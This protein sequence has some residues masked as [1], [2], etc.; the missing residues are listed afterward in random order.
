MQH[1]EDSFLQSGIIDQDDFLDFTQSSGDM[2][3]YP[4]TTPTTVPA[5]LG[6]KSFWEHDSSMADISMD[7]MAD[8]SSF[9][10]PSQQVSSMEDWSRNHQISQDSSSKGP[11]MQRALQPARRH[12]PLMAKPPASSMEQSISNTAFDFNMSSIPLDPFARYVSSGVVDP[13]LIFSFSEVAPQLQSNQ[14]SG[15]ATQRSVSMVGR[16]TGEPYGHQERGSL[17]NKQELRR[18]RSVKENVPQMS[19]DRARFGSPVD[20]NRPGSRRSVSDARP[21]RRETANDSQP[22]PNFAG[23]GVYSSG[24]QPTTKQASRINLTSIPEAA[25][26]NPRTSVTFSIDENGRARTETTVIMDGSRSPRRARSSASSNDRESPQSGS[27]TDEDP[28]TIP[29]RNASF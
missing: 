7:F 18:P 13:G 21:K 20:G 26:L 22:P 28:I 24:R 3:A 12:R 2:F 29:S 5:Y 1:D 8:E 15:S 17:R 9:Y 14:N 10:V 19:Y 4:M 25:R 23:K 27:S 11:P 6:D 16:T